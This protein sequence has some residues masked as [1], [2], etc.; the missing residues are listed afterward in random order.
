MRK[1]LLITIILVSSFCG[2]TGSSVIKAT[3]PYLSWSNAYIWEP[4]FDIGVSLE[5][6]NGYRTIAFNE[7]QLA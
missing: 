2:L 3:L 6:F 4:Y 1:C 5:L 7:E